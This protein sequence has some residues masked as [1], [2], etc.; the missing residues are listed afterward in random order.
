MENLINNKMWLSHPS[1]FN[2]PFDSQP[3]YK[4]ITLEDW[5]KVNLK[6]SMHWPKE[7][8]PEFNEDAERELKTVFNKFFITCFSNSEDEDRDILM[9]SHYANAHK[10]FCVKYKVL[11]VVK[12]HTIVDKSSQNDSVMLEMKAVE[13]AKKSPVYSPADHALNSEN[14][15][16]EEK[17]IKEAVIKTLKTKFEVW[18]Y[19]KEYR[20]VYHPSKKELA[21]QTCLLGKLIDFPEDMLDIEGITFGCKCPDASKEAIKEII[22]NKWPYAEFRKCTQNFSNCKLKSE[23]L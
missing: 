13:Y 9:W 15:K 19:E 2:D 21:D 16:D 5:E 3:T 4:P 12:H 14:D 11:Q 18:E 1:T 8:I 22:K 6:K 10:G 17:L 23:N 20:I 7:K